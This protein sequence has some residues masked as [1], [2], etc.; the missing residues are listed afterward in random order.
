MMISL[1]RTFIIRC[2]VRIT[3]GAR[4]LQ[5]FR[6][7]PVEP[8]SAILVLDGANNIRL[9]LP[10]WRNSWCCY[11]SCG[12]GSAPSQPRSG[13]AIKLKIPTLTDSIKMRA[14]A[15]TEIGKQKALRD[16]KL[17]TVSLLPT[18][19]ARPV[20]VLQQI[21]SAFERGWSALSRRRAVVEEGL[22]QPSVRNSPRCLLD[23]TS[24]AMIPWTHCSAPDM[25]Q[26]IIARR[27]RNRTARKQR[28]ALSRPST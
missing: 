3:L 1:T 11:L 18:R 23:R 12:T 15:P 27:G 24:G 10:S 22:V 5:P 26:S 16:P 21:C 9:R 13:N 19:S 7:T 8:M 28:W 20:L 14:C 25:T 6:R 4:S 17:V 2:L